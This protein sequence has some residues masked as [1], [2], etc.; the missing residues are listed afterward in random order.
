[1][2]QS[3][4]Y[5][6]AN[7]PGNRKLNLIFQLS[8]VGASIIRMGYSSNSM[9][10][11]WTEILTPAAKATASSKG[12]YLKEWYTHVHLFIVLQK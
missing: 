8:L 10:L 6:V 7:Y 9:G 3:K 1:M 12:L 11:E 5:P 2:Q 4:S